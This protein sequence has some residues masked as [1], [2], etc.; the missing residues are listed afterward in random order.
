MLGL[1]CQVIETLRTF[2]SSANLRE[3]M[4][5][6]CMIHNLFDEYKF[7]YNYPD[8][9]RSLCRHYVGHLLPLHLVLT[10]VQYHPSAVSDSIAPQ[11][12][13]R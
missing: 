6:R 1:L 12:L 4:V 7:F 9:V 5:F 2:K 11:H 8:K 13:C 10:A 3:R